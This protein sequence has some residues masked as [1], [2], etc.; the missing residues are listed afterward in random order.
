MAGRSVLESDQAQ[1]SLHAAQIEELSQALRDAEQKLL[2]ATQRNAQMQLREQERNR[3]TNDSLVQAR[4]EL[5]DVQREMA[6]RE[7]GMMTLISMHQQHTGRRR[8][9]A[10][11]SSL[12]RKVRELETELRRSGVGIGIG[13]TRRQT[14]FLMKL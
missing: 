10:V 8:G 4:Q 2:T 6:Q 3:L 7:A 12:Q 1:R 14:S 13:Q 11:P 5:A 9:Y